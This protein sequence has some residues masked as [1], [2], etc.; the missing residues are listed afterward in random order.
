MRIAAIDVGS[1]SIHMIVCRIRPDLSFEVIDREKDMIRLAAGTLAT[2]RLPD[3]NIATA[4]QTLA[5]YRRLAES[6]GVEE[7]LV[8]ATSAVREAENGSDLI[9]QASQQLGLRVRVISGSEEARLIHLAAAYAVGTG[10][11]RAVTIDI[12]GGSTEITLGTAARME[13][14]RSFKIGTIRLA[15][16]FATRDPLPRR[17]I[18]R[19]EA[20]I[21]RQTSGF[22]QQIRRRGFSRVIGTSGTLLT[23]GTLATGTS[24][25]SPSDL[26]RL[27]VPSDAIRKLRKRLVTMSLEERLKI[28]GLDPRRADLAPIGA[29]LAEALLDRLRADELTLSDFALREGLVLDYIRRNSKH[30]RAAER[31]PDVRRRSV[32]ELGE[33]CSYYPDHAAQVAQLALAIFDATR[34]RHKLGG[35]EREWLEF[36][37]LLHDV[38][39]HISYEA[40]HKHAYYLIRHGDLRGFD[41]VEVDVIALIARYHRLATPKKGHEGFGELPR[42][43]RKTVKVLGAMVRLAEGLDRSHKQVVKKLTA[44]ATKKALDIS[45]RTRG[46]AELELWAARR[47][48]LPL[49]EELELEIGFQPTP[50]RAPAKVKGRKTHKRATLARIT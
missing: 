26:R 17:D 16:K 3:A 33:R 49:A 41:P 23:I 2:G 19:I 37:A 25:R 44:R 10:A 46:D 31:Y 24:P 34:D 11:E 43:L 45:L 36:G 7:I 40:H 12:G 48:A 18:Q 35:R 42:P 29:I 20:H 8:A 21:A 27:V 32:I 22:L 4:M 6:H 47:H 28:P 15:E 50:R 13:A 14:G 5:K 1:N 38:G 39:I 9:T 30:I